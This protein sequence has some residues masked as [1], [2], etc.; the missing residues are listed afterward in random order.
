MPILSFLPFPFRF[1]TLPRCLPP[2][3]VPPSLLPLSPSL[4]PSLPHSPS[5]PP[6][7]SSPSLPP[8]LPSPSPSPSLPPSLPAYGYG[9]LMV[10][11]ICLVSL[12]GLLILPCAKHP[13]FKKYYQYFL[14][15]LISLGASALF[16]DAVLHLAPEV[17]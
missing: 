11:I 5:L 3:L 13:R 12:L 2:S 15:L 9:F 4:P 16:S 10:V 17:G 14:A 7:S 8:S 1:F 6:S